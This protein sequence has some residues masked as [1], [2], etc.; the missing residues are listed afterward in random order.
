MGTQSVFVFC[1]LSGIGCLVASLA[2]VRWNWRRDVPAFGRHS[3]VLDI[4][5]HPERYATARVIPPV[6]AFIALGAMLLMVAI[7]SLIFEVLAQ[8]GR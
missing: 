1:L 4:A 6:R 7:G 2:V 5:L 8:V 3:D